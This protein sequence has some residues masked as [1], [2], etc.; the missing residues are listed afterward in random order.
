MDQ[1]QEMP[2]SA[3]CGL[4]FKILLVSFGR[5]TN[6]QVPLPSGIVT[7]APGAKGAPWWAPH[8]EC[9]SCRIH[10]GGPGCEKERERGGGGKSWVTRKHGKLEEIVASYTGQWK[11]NA[12][13]KHLI[14]KYIK[15]CQ[16]E[17]GIRAILMILSGQSYHRT[18]WILLNI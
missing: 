7:E 2:K 8:P 10:R 13:A 15:F 18:K 14:S 11:Q 9:N 6:R 4:R 17:K 16:H 3:R 12:V 5:W 1:L